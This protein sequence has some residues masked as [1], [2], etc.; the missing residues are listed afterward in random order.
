[1]RAG[2]LYGPHD[3]RIEDVADP[4]C[5]PG[6]VMI[7]VSY[8]G[9]CGTDVSEFSKG[10]GLV[11]LH[12]RHLGSGHIGPTVLGHEFIGTVIDAGADATTYK[13]QRVACGAGVSCG[14]CKWCRAGRTNLCERYYTLGFST[15]GGLAEYVSAPAATCR[16][17]P[18]SCAD[19]DAALAQP[20]AVGIHA[21][22]RAGVRPGDTVVLLGVGSIGSFVAAALAGH[23]GPIIA[24]DIE[25]GRLD[26]ARQLGA[27]ETHRIAPDASPSE[28]RELVPAGA[29]VV[30]E[31]AG[32]PGSA[33]RALAIAVRGG[34]VMVV[35]LSQSPESL[36]LDNVVLREV[37]LKTSLAHVCDSDLPKALDLLAR[38]S[39][40][41][42]L[43]DR[44]VPL[45]DVVVGG[46]ERLVDGHATGK[47]LVD[48]RHS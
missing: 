22:N 14:A 30:F 17:I 7:E 1:M 6:D 2:V 46:F 31:T 34:T 28:A 27:T 29:D 18:D 11:P 45:A 12:T 13:G 32:V 47:I 24:L 36:E 8:N 19:L 10:H 23:D 38:R 48:P 4:T 26:V 33:S 40:S 39:L 25:D 41:T 9:L 35:G 42:L 37:D 15:H 44:V 20:L 5:R 21:T 16:S 3:L 43:L